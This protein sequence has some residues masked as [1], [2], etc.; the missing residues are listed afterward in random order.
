VSIPTR[1]EKPAELRGKSIKYAEPIQAEWGRTYHQYLCLVFTDGTKAL[2]GGELVGARWLTPDPDLAEMKKAPHFFTP[3]D[4]ADKA[5]KDAQ[6]QLEYE[7]R[8]EDRERREFERLA[9][10]FAIPPSEKEED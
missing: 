7:H 4:L 1:I 3:D 10:R 8:E 2:L 9:K 6:R 5:R